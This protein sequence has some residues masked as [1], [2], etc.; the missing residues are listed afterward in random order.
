M[1]RSP[2]IYPNGHYMD[3]FA[4][5][6]IIVQGKSITRE[7]W[8]DKE[9]ECRCTM[10]REKLC[11]YREEDGQWHPWTITTDD[12]AGDDWVVWEED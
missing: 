7:L 9:P 8:Q 2:L 6:N 1:S 11:I 5:L 12:M 4:A 10:I 3:F